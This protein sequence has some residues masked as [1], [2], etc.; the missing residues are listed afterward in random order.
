M[1]EQAEPF[2]GS[3]AIL[4]ARPHKPG[5]ETVND[6]DPM[7]C[8]F[9]RATIHNRGEVAAYAD[10]PANETDLYARHKWLV[11][12][13]EGLKEKLED[14]PEYYDAKIAG[15]WVWGISLWIGGGFCSGAVHRKLL[16]L[17]DAGMGVHRRQIHLGGHHGQGIMA[18]ETN[19]NLYKLFDQLSER[20][21]RVRVCCGDWK[22]ICGQSPTYHNGLTGVFLDP[23]YGEK[24]NRSQVYTHD[25]LTVADDVRAWSI[26]NGN[27][28]LMRIALCGY[29]GEHEEL[30]DHGWKPHYWKT[31]GG[32]GNMSDGQGR[33]NAKREVIWFSPH[34]LDETQMTMF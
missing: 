6:I 14:D 34:C 19:A 29:A 8:N 23:P 7:I 1:F 32:Y 31:Q 20:L 25:S 17:G 13:K 18:K 28:K 16:H 15:W 9:F 10:Y 2:F 24:A 11:G 26:A 21:K 12:Q 4:L 3:G 30:Q 27:N 22:R 5:I 33:D